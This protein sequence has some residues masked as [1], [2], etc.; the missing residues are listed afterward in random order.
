MY[1]SIPSV[2][3]NGHTGSS[4]CLNYYFRCSVQ[5]TEKARRMQ[6]SH[7]LAILV[8]FNALHLSKVNKSVYASIPSLRFLLQNDHI[9]VL[10]A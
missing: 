8:H 9:S 3:R 6:W 5:C 1:I 4:R 7:H 2:Q 10:V